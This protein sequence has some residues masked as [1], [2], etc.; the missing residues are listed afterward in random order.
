MTIKE[1]QE[2]IIRTINETGMP[3]DILELI[4]ENLIYSLRQQMLQA[5]KA[6]D[7]EPKTR[8]EIVS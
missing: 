5:E 3:A 2:R 4:L 8:T 6:A 7:E 1:A